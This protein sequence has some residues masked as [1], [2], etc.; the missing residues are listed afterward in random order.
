MAGWRPSRRLYNH[1]S[2]VLHFVRRPFQ[3][4]RDKDGVA[5]AVAIEKDVGAKLHVEETPP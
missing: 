1:G 2:A 4:N 5:W 3:F